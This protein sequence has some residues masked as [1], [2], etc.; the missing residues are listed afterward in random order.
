MS[1]HEPIESE[2]AQ[3][4]RAIAGALRDYL[5]REYGFAV[6]VFKYGSAHRVNYVSSADR[7]DMIAALKGLL[8]RFEG[9]HPEE[10]RSDG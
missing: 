4:M 5:P 6:L 3:H 1:T 8:A 10:Q 7:G 2:A 9:P